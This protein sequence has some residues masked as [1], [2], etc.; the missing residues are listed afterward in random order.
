CAKFFGVI[1]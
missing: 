1:W